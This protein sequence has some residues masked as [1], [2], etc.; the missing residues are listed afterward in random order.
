MNYTFIGTAN[1]GYL[2]I[3]HHDEIEIF[4]SFANQFS[5]Y[6]FCNGWQRP[7]LRNVLDLCYSILG[8][9]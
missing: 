6:F 8:S 1:V 9:L 2:S 3:K 4:E 7:G 5:S